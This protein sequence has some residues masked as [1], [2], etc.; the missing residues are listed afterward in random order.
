MESKAA[1]SRVMT[2]PLPLIEDVLDEMMFFSN[3]MPEREERMSVPPA[4]TMLDVGDEANVIVT[5]VL[6]R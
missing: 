4:M 2:C 5:V 6:A 3:N 1:I